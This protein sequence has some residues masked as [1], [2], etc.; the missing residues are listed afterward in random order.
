[1]I[2]IEQLRFGYPADAFVLR[3]DRLE[4]AAGECVAL[5][6]RAAAARRP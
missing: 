1:M 4:I 6:G 3:V 2:R 5:I